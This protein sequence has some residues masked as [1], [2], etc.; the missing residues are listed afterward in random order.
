M[1][2]VVVALT[3]AY[4]TVGAVPRVSGSLGNI[5]RR[6]V[7]LSPQPREGPRGD[8]GERGVQ[9]HTGGGVGDHGRHP[10][11]APQPH[12]QWQTG[13]HAPHISTV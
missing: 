2:H 12:P 8:R 4:G 5:N 7:V 10:S 13:R 11:P 6:H 1:C 9:Q 3:E